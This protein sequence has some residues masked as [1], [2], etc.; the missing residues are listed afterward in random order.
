MYYVLCNNPTL[1]IDTVYCGLT[2]ARKSAL[3]IVGFAQV[4]GY[5][6]LVAILIIM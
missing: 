5:K 6:L 1:S 4:G 3:A 2:E